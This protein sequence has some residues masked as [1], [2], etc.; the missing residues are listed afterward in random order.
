[1]TAD[2]VDAD[3]DERSRGANPSSEPALNVH[4]R[5]ADYKLP[6]CPLPSGQHRDRQGCLPVGG[7]CPPVDSKLRE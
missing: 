2:T 5:D 3:M 1:M 7:S 6:P 4:G